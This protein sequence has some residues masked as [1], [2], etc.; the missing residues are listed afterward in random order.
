MT[1]LKG[2]SCEEQLKAFGFCCSAAEHSHCCLQLSEEGGGDKGVISSAWYP[3]VGGVGML[4]SC[5]RGA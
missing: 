1:G 3:V 2:V 5:S 4:L